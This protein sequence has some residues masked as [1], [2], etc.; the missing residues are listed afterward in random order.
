M[1]KIEMKDLLECGVHFGHQTRAWNPKM[2]QYIYQA[3]NG[4]HIIDLKQT[5]VLIDEAY[6]ALK[7]VAEEGGN[8]LFV[9]TKKQAQEVIK[10]EA[11]R[12]GVFYVNNRWL[13]GMLTNFKTIRRSIFRLKK[14]ESM[15]EEGIFDLLTKKETLELDR[16]REKL[17]ANL[18]G[19]K[20]M[21]QLPDIMLVVDTDVEKIAVSEAQKLNIPIIGMLDTNCDPTGIDYL[22][23]SNDDAIRSIKLIVSKMADAVLAGKTG[24]DEEITQELEENLKEES[25]EETEKEISEENF[26]DSEKVEKNEETEEAKEDNEETIEE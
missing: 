11:E 24:E 7:K 5:E 17:E 12:A 4:I 23:P 6:E 18:G 8:I 13:G 9:G 19:I 2:K 15:E 16:E 10:E 20:E 1:S 26:E 21:E 25:T 3:R 22:I 14:I